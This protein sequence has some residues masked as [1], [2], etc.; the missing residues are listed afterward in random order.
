M[1]LKQDRILVPHV[2]Y[3]FWLVDAFASAPFEG[4]P[5]AVVLLTE[6]VSDPF[7]QRVAKEFNLSETAFLTPRGHATWSLRWFTPALEVDLC[8]HAT[9]AAAWALFQEGLAVDRVVFQTRSGPLAVNREGGMLAMDFPA[10]DSWKGNVDQRLGQALGQPPCEQFGSAMDIVALF[11]DE[12]T[13]AGLRPDFRLL[14][15]IECRGVIATAPSEQPGID[16]VSRFFAPRCGIDEDPVTGSAHCLLGPFW[17]NRLG[18]A[19]LLGRQI[20]RRPGTVSVTV[21]GKGVTLKGG[22]CIVARGEIRG[23]N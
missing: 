18:C 6:P 20:S 15:Q 5:A 13:V 1:D 4:N 19:T 2:F 17:A 9:L 3:R 8:G 12:A 7:Q 11:P 14:A 16:F 23:D 21:T 10:L 22:A